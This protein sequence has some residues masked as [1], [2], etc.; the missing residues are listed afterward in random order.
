MIKN[1]KELL[2]IVLI[3]LIGV[4]FILLLAFNVKQYDK[5]FPNQEINNIEINS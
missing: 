5:K 1:K 4:I 2:E 3:F